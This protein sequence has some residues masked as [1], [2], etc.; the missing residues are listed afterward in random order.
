MQLAVNYSPQ[1][2][3]L[4]RAGAITLDRWKCSDWPELTDG[5]RATGLPLYLHFELQVGGG[6]DH[7]ADLDHVAA[8]SDDIHAPF[9]NL[10]VATCRTDYPTIPIESTDPVDVAYVASRTIQDVRVVTNRFSTDR[11]LLI[12]QRNSDTSSSRTAK[13]C[14]GSTP[15]WAR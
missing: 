6:E 15:A 13:T 10:H 8:A 1:A 4:V 7:G 11:V 9:I 12:A 2:A 3:E 14:A 5:A